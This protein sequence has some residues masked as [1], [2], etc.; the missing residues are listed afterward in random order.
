MTLRRLSEGPAHTSGEIQNDII[1]AFTK[2]V[3]DKICVN[4]RNAGMY[5]IL[6]AKDCSKK[7]QLSLVVRYVD[8]DTA[9]IFEHFLS[10]T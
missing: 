5:S 6:A 4:V 2:M 9:T 8:V 10:H 7:E 3:S 1:E